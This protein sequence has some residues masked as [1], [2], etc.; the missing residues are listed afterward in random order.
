MIYMYTVNV[1]IFVQYIF[2]CI[3]R[4]ALDVQKCVVS[5]NYNRNRTKRINWHVRRNLTM[6]ICLLR[7]DAGKFIN[8]KI[9]HSIYVNTMVI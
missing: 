2:S 4:R 1:D 8:A 9:S 6:Q 3:S 7:F 5:K